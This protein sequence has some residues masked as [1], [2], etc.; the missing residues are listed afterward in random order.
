MTTPSAPKTPNV[1]RIPALDAD[2]GDRVRAAKAAQFDAILEHEGLRAD[3]DRVHVMGPFANEYQV[4]VIDGDVRWSI[5]CNLDAPAK[6]YEV[7]RR[8]LIP[9][10][11]MGRLTCDWN[12]DDFYHLT[13]DPPLMPVPENATDDELRAVG[14]LD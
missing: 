9:L 11:E 13:F 14:F 1:I 2:A 6:C 12:C 7:R 3:D 8:R 5:E 4:I 10:P